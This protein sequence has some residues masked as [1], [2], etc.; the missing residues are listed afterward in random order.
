MNRTIGL[1]KI[2]TPDVVCKEAIGL[3]GGDQTLGVQPLWATHF[4]KEGGGLP[5]LRIKDLG[6][7]RDCRGDFIAD[8]VARAEE[9]K[10]CHLLR[11][12][13][14]DLDRNCVRHSGKGVLVKSPAAEPRNNFTGGGWLCRG[15]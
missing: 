6:C 14:V 15:T 4:F 10:I 9:K 8:T 2:T 7:E 11:S 5:Q 12:G 3:G 1:C 13:C